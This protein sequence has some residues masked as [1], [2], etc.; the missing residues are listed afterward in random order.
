MPYCDSSLPFFQPLSS[1]FWHISV[2]C[3]I[4]LL[5]LAGMLMPVCL[6][7]GHPVNLSCFSAQH[8]CGDLV[9]YCS[10][11]A[12]ARLIALWPLIT[13]TFLSAT[14]RTFFTSFSVKSLMWWKFRTSATEILKPKSKDETTAWIWTRGSWAASA[15]LH[16]LA[17]YI[18]TGRRI[19]VDVLKAFSLRFGVTV[20]SSHDCFSRWSWTELKEGERVTL[21]HTHRKLEKG[22]S[23]IQVSV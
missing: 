15:E 19:R 12:P 9:S 7:V 14:H 20:Q 21:L 18:I 6:K 8:S 3:I 4:E 2:H 17:D 5:L 22:E 23:P 10:L 13:R 16:G 1:Q 11:S